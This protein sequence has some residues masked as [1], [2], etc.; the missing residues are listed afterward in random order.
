MGAMLVSVRVRVGLQGV[1]EEQPATMT[2]GRHCKAPFLVAGLGTQ[3]RAACAH[4]KH[5]ARHWRDCGTCA[6][7]AARTPDLFADPLRKTEAQNIARQLERE[8]QTRAAQIPLP[9]TAKR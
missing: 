1:P 5:C 4:H 9:L 8:Q 6:G 7:A 2:R 3:A